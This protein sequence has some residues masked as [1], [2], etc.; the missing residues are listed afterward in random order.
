VKPLAAEFLKK[1]AQENRNPLGSCRIHAALKR[2]ERYS[3][4]LA[5]P[6]PRHRREPTMSSITQGETM[7]LFN[8]ND[9]QPEVPEIEVQGDHAV[10]PEAE[11]EE[12]AGKKPKKVYF[13]PQTWSNN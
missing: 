12:K 8:R 7:A 3:R 9:K 11:S 4:Q 13:D 1:A 10:I 5:K 6:H 2:E